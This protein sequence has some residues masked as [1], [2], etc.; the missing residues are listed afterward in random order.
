MLNVGLKV[1]LR[2]VRPSATGVLVTRPTMGAHEN[3]SQAH[4]FDPGYLVSA[5]FAACRLRGGTVQAE[6][7]LARYHSAVNENGLE[8]GVAAVD[9]RVDDLKNKTVSS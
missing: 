5:P 8:A 6:D 1:S 9:H 2:K 7:V 4:G 3:R